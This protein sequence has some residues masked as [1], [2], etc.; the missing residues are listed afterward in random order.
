MFTD[1]VDSTRQLIAHGDREWKEILDRH[2]ALLDRA[3]ERYRGRKVNA[4]G[5]GV[6]G[7]F[8]GPARAVQ[9]ACAIRDGVAALGIE[10]RAGVHTG[11]IEL[12]GDD[13]SGVAVHLGARVAA[14]AGPS[15]VLVTRTVT[16]LVNG[17]GLS[18]TEHGE[19]ELKGLP[20]SWPLYT[21]DG[22]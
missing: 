21:V 4:T 9:C 12:R 7:T 18:F 19:H 13:V 17:S 16:D 20:G 5:D 3:L 14:L 2:D 11:E 15:Q 22:P 8:D 1:I 10:V 6:L